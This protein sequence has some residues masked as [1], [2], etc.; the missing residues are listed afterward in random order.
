MFCTV[1]QKLLLKYYRCFLFKTYF[2]ARSIRNYTQFCTSQVFYLLYN[3]INQHLLKT[4]GGSW[5]DW[6]WEEKGTTEDEMVG[7]HHWLNGHEFELTLGVDDGQG[8]LACCS[9]WSHKESDTTER[10]N[11]T[12][13]NWL[14][15]ALALDHT[16]KFFNL[17]IYV[18]CFQKIKLADSHYLILRLTLKLQ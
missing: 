13:L 9:P 15:S 3:Q 7:W 10:L 18:S 6:R 16:F 5:E 2:K 8:Y 14:K 1:S 17:K 12:E 11:W 4:E